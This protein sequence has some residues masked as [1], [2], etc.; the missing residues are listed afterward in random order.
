M[1]YELRHYQARPGYREEWVRYMEDVIIPSQ[2][3]KG[4]VIT[5]SFVDEEHE[6]GYVWM[7][8]LRK[9]GTA[10]ATLHSHL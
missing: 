3:S 10:Q 5:A 7:R 4:M 1:F 8:L 9:R 2:V 6:D